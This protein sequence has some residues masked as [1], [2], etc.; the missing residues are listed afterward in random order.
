MVADLSVLSSPICWKL[1]QSP[2]PLAESRKPSIFFR[3]RRKVES[4]FFSVAPI[5][6]HSSSPF[7]VGTRFMLYRFLSRC[8][9][10][11]SAE[12]CNSLPSLQLTVDFS[13]PVPICRAVDRCFSPPLASSLVPSSVSLNYSRSVSSRLLSSV[14][15]SRYTILFFVDSLVFPAPSSWFHPD[16]PRYAF[17][18]CIG[19]PPVPLYVNW[20]T[21]TAE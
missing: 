16:S 20:R 1:I 14:S 19:C 13:K 11:G 4:R 17:F 6:E 15:L 2:S 21:D 9:F 7:V 8:L 18:S 5:T 12:F 10:G 3:R